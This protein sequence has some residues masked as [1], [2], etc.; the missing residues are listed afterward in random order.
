MVADILDYRGAEGCC[1]EKDQSCVVL[2]VG[3]RRRDFD[4]DEEDEVEVW[5]LWFW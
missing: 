1:R 4:G 3:G 2:V 5:W